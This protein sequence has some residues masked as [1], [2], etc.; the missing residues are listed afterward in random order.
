MATPN[1]W[2]CAHIHDHAILFL[3]FWAFLDVLTTW[4]RKLNPSHL[5]RFWGE[6]NVTCTLRVLYL[7]EVKNPFLVETVILTGMDQNTFNL[8]FFEHLFFFWMENFYFIIILLLY[9]IIII[10]IIIII[11]CKI[12]KCS[13]TVYDKKVLLRRCLHII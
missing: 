11:D 8:N 5:V 7:W 2:C 10:I 13:K 3:S 4:T 1:S 12:S 6:L 9:Y